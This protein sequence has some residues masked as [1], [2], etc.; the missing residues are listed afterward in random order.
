MASTGHRG[1]S[2]SL[3][4]HCS[5]ST[6][7]VVFLLTCLASRASG[8]SRDVQAKAYPLLDLLCKI[9]SGQHQSMFVS[10]CS[11]QVNIT[12]G[13]I[14]LVHS[15]GPD[16]LGL[17]TKV[18]ECMT[19]TQEWKDSEGGPPHPHCCAA[20]LWASS[21]LLRCGHLASEEEQVLQSITSAVITLVGTGLDHWARAQPESTP[22]LMVH[23]H[24][25]GPGQSKAAS[26]T[27]MARRGSRARGG[28]PGL[29]VILAQK[30]G[31]S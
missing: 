17:I 18:L 25:R 19:N 27:D 12:N 8:H 30:K 13:Q 6:W 16:L 7:L 10:D 4:G 31:G 20:W 23:T 2:K 22:F 26:S 1:Q 3:F 24:L 15:H 5:T 21:H 14:Q 28:N 11:V 9:S 29:R